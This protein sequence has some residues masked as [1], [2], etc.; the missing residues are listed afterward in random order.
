MLALTWSQITLEVVLGGLLIAVARATD[1]SL[2]V[3]RQASSIR[4]YRKSALFIAF[5]EALIW[6]FVVAGVIKNLANPVYALFYAC[7]FALGTFVGV[8]IEGL[9]ARGEQVIRIFTHRG[10]EMAKRFRDMGLR[11]TLFEGKGLKGPIS[12]LFIQVARRKAR[13]LMPIA[14]ECDDEC[15]IVVDDIRSSSVGAHHNTTIISK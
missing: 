11:V 10:D 15:F 13:T 4:G 14:R 12:L 9:L 5:F 7:G 8:T 6:V 2:G 3:L 1:V